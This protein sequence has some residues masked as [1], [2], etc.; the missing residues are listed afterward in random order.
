M[1]KLI[2]VFS[3]LLC[4]LA[5]Y[6]QT[7]KQK[8]A[9]YTDDKSGKNYAD[10]AGEFLTNA[11]VKRGVYDAYERTADFL[12]LLSQEQGYQRSGAVNESQIAK[13]GVQ[14][15]VQLVCAVKIGLMDNQLFISAKLIDVETGGIKGTARP[16]MFTIGDFDGFEKVCEKITASMFGES[17]IEVSVKDYLA[18]SNCIAVFSTFSPN[19]VY[20]YCGVYPQ[21]FLPNNDEVAIKNELQRT[22]D[23]GDIEIDGNWNHWPDPEINIIHPNTTYIYYAYAVDKN[24]NRGQITRKIIQTPA[25]ETAK[26]TIKIKKISGNVVIVDIT[27]NKD[28]A[29]YIFAIEELNYD[30][31][32][33][34]EFING[35]H[36]YKTLNKQ[37][38]KKTESLINFKTTTLEAKKNYVLYTV[39][40]SNDG[41]YGLVDKQYIKR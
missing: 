1:R 15:G 24:G 35:A 40:Y 2:L 38:Y 10:F 36:Y 33:D 13:L 9:I 26:A 3:I 7:T 17:N 8:V 20:F 11:I 41:K 22:G 25:P 27:K 18:T 21:G 6:A 28:C 14:L 23:Q 30:N 19:A 32:P 5:S 37:D 29:Y 16:A 12:N 34:F 39:A 4:I 31:L